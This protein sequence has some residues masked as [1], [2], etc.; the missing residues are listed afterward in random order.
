MKE[1]SPSPAA[2]D[3]VSAGETDCNGQRKRTIP[4]EDLFN[5]D[6][7]ETGV[8][9]GRRSRHCCSHSSRSSQA[10][11]KRRSALRRAAPTPAR[12]TLHRETSSRPSIDPTSAPTCC[13][14][15]ASTPRTR[16]AGRTSWSRGSPG[17]IFA[18]PI[19]QAKPQPDRF[20]GA[21]PD[22]QHHKTD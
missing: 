1:T 7:T 15:P 2:F 10:A 13:W 20:G 11:D 22:P 14:Y 6:A 21:H 17:R 3:D 12:S 19:A 16:D 18:L 4:G 5:A 9:T 8:G